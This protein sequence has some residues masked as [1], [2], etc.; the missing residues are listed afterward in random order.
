M[1]RGFD[2]PHEGDSIFG[3]MLKTV[4]TKSVSLIGNYNDE[5]DQRGWVERARWEGKGGGN[6]GG[7]V[8]LDK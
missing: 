4:S 5:P 8:E 3:A 2:S 6:F 7:L 1:K